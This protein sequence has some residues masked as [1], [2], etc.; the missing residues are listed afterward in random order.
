MRKTFSIKTLGCKLNQYE[1]KLITG[2]FLSKG[3]VAK[4]FGEA[5]D[6]VIVN[7][8]TVTDKSDKK[9]RNYIRQ[10]KKFSKIGKTYVTGCLTRREDN[11]LE[12]LNNIEII[13]YKDKDFFY[14]KIVAD[15]GLVDD[16]INSTQSSG[17]IPEHRTRAF[18]K[19]QDGCDG[20]CSYCIIPAVKGLPVSRSMDDLLEETSNLIQSGVSEIV[21]TGITIG[22]YNDRGK[23]LA[24]LA[25]ELLSLNNKNYRIRITSIEPE[26]VT[27]R[28][29]ELY[30]NSKLCNHI[31]VPLQS[32]SSRILKYMK[33]TYNQKEYLQKIEMIRRVNPLISIGT[34][35]IV[36]FPNELD[37]DFK[38]TLSVVKK[39]QFSYIHQFR[40]SPRTGTPA[41]EM[42]QEN[43]FQE[44]SKRLEF[45]KLMAIENSKKYAETFIGSNL[46]CIV[47]PNNKNNE[48]IATSDTYLKIK[49]ENNNEN[50]IE[51]GKLST[52]K[53]I[54]VGDN[55]DNKGVLL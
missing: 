4:P 32:G 42:K 6:V 18:L 54:S 34:D 2:K 15:L 8:C 52:V 24:D 50:N 9:C 17:F 44:I 40:Y 36:G 25:R 53:L 29:L 21:L 3:W 22:K 16:K 26:H 30:K 1:S 46:E 5:V 11:G 13:D 10:G 31:H 19:I 28:L 47:E 41:A 12:N 33:R 45:L 27:D 55:G 39:S 35:I 43:S 7:T 38:E 37:E 51:T 23:D 20:E 14:S 49:I 48:I